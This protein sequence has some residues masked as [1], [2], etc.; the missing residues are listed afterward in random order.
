MRCKK[1]ENPVEL[2]RMHNSVVTT[3]VSFTH[4]GTSHPEASPKTLGNPRVERA[5]GTVVAW[6]ADFGF[7]RIFKRGFSSC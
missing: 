1:S 5:L 4:E 2:P 3:A 6:L 7:A